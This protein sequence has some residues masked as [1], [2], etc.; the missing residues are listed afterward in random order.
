MKYIFYSKFADSIFLAKLLSDQGKN[1]AYYIHDKDC[2]N[3]GKNM[4]INI[5]KNFFKELSKS[6]PK[7]TIV[8]FDQTGFGSLGDFLKKKGWFIHGASEFADKL[9]EDRTFATK[10]FA[11][12]A[13]VPKTTTFTD[14]NSAKLFLRHKQ[15]DE[16]FVFKPE[17]EDMPNQW[18][19]VSKDIADMISKLDYYKTCWEH[20]DIKFELQEFIKGLEADFS[21]YM[22]VKGQWIEGAFEWYFEDKKFLNGDIGPTV[23]CADSMLYYTSSKEPYF[24]EHLSKLTNILKENGFT[25]QIALN[26]I[27]SE[28][29]HKAYVLEATPRFGYDS[30]QNEVYILDEHNKDITKL[31]DAVA[32]G[33]PLPKNYFPQNI[34]GLDVRISVPPYPNDDFA[35]KSK[36]HVVNFDKS[37]KEH[38]YFHDIMFNKETDTYEC[39]GSYGSVGVIVTCDPSATICIDKMY[40][41]LIPKLNISEAQYRTDAG[42]RVPDDVKKLKEWGIL[43]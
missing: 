3:V 32:I 15:K 39:T 34:W 27:F 43:L 11:N 33:T 6:D 9:E 14:F 12:I 40:K 26:N 42:K 7:Q 2:K 10:L 17:G 35:E 18:T 23:G 20:G 36:G 13:N 22:N 8:I 5:I 4:G 28:M 29:D 16:R 1:I 38:F 31:F 25:G 30:M 19:Y 41:E 37:L 21:G 24:K